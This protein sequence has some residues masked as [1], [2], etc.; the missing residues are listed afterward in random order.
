MIL[1]EWME[2]A[3]RERT[4]AFSTSIQIR[5]AC[6]LLSQKTRDVLQPLIVYSFLR[7]STC[8]QAFFVRV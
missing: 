8:G 7:R 5:S 1:N 6:V 4:G 3:A 2:I